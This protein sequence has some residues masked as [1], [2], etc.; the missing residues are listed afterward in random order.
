MIL[1]MVQFK[2]WTIII[3]EKPEHRYVTF[4][5]M[6]PDVLL[7]GSGGIIVVPK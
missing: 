4:I 2:N 1:E 7:A 6:L 3:F 5:N